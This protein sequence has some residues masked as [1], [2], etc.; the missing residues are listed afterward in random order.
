MSLRDS[1]LTIRLNTL[2]VRSSYVPD[3]ES[4]RSTL[5]GSLLMA[6]PDVQPYSFVRS[7]PRC[8]LLAFLRD[9][10]SLLSQLILPIRTSIR[11]HI[12]APIADDQRTPWRGPT[13]ELW[14]LPAHLSNQL[15]SPMDPSVSR[16][17]LIFL[18]SCV[19]RIASPRTNDRHRRSNQQRF[20]LPRSRTRCNP[21]PSTDNLTFDAHGRCSRSR[22]ALTRT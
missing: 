8:V 15:P 2:S 18:N 19:A 21:L 5:S 17:L 7:R 13:A 22:L 12:A 10:S 11:G 14:S 20:N 6:V 9:Q 1:K 16:V 3:L 4:D